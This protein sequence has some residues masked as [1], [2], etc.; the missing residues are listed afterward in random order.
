M[1]I[2]DIRINTACGKACGWHDV[3]CKYVIPISDR[4]GVQHLQPYCKL[5][6]TW[7]DV[8]GKETRQ[9]FQCLAMCK[10]IEKEPEGEF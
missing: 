5:F 1:K 10:R 4:E 3:R 8:C 2:Y 7:L 6:D 9:Y